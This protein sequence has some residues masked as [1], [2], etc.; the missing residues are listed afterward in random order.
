MKKHRLNIKKIIFGFVGISISVWL[1]YNFG[2]R[3]FWGI[4]TR[5]VE[6]GEAKSIIETTGIAVRDEFILENQS[7][8]SGNLKYLIS[9]GEKVSK[10]GVIAEVYSSPEDAKASYKIDNLNKELEIL[11]KLN[12]SKYNIAKGINFIN[13]QIND[14]IKNLLISLGDIKLLDSKN[15]REKILY[16]LNER[17]IIMGKDVNL[18]NKIKDLNKEKSEL[19]SSFSKSISN[20]TSPESGDFITYIDGYEGF[21]DYKNILTSDFENLNFEEINNNF[22]KPT[23]V[24]Q[25]GKIIKSEMWYMV[26][27]INEEDCRK[28]HV[29]DEVIVNM[30]LQDYIQNIPCLVKLIV[31]KAN[32]KDYIIVISCNYMNKGLACIR[33]EN[34]KIILNEYSGLKLNKSAVHKSLDSEGNEIFGVYVKC[35]K[36]LKFKKINPIFWG[37]S[38]ICSYTSEEAAN[39]KYLQLGD[40]VV[41]KGVNLFDG[42]CVS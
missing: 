34:I 19:N 27:V 6:R 15:Y 28:I 20:I 40:Y 1:I 42:K 38:I 2:I 3:K 29:N 21:T 39:D 22:Y 11:E 4:E 12:F 5:L 30:P 35:D 24:H 37:E 36:Y 13:N 7:Y 25:L 18:E 9:D 23:D 10:N 31:P 8:N 26:C 17:E 14:E 41:T 16:L 32:S 33:K